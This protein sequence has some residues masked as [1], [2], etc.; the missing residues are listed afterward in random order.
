MNPKKIILQFCF[1]LMTLTIYPQSYLPGPGTMDRYTVFDFSQYWLTATDTQVFYAS[2]DM[3]IRGWQKWDRG[4]THPNDYD[5]SIVTEYHKRN[6]PFIGGMTTTVYFFDEAADSAQFKDMVTHDASGNVIPRNIVG[7]NN[8]RAN[9]ASPAY[10]DYIVS[11]AKIQIDGGVDGLCFDE[12]LSGYDGATYNGN[13][14]FDDY[15]IRDFNVY[16]AAKYPDYT[17]TDW[18]NKFG[19]S[20]SNYINTAQPLDDLNKNFN[21]REYLGIHGWQTN[22]LISSNPLAV[23]WGRVTDNRA[24]TRS[25]TF[26]AKYTMLYWQDIVSRVRQYARDTYGKEILISSNGVFPYVDF[27]ELGMYEFNHDDNGAEASYVP[28]LSGHL[29]GSV[30]LQNL[31]K[32]LYQRN[33]EIAG[34]VPLVLFIDWPTNIMNDYYNLP[35]NEKED[36]WKIYA[37][38]AYANGL[39]M[40]FHLRTAM[41]SDPTATSQ[42]MLD[43]F[44]NYHVFY[45]ENASLFHHN[46]I[47]DRPLK[48]SESG[49]NASLI[50]HPDAS[51]YTI[52]L[53]NHNYIPGKGMI[54]KEGFTVLFH[55]D[56]VPDLVYVKSPDFPGKQIINST[57]SNGIFKITVD[58][59]HYYDI[60][61]LDY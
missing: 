27:N 28:V 22:P 41:P 6:L 34:E 56:S 5:F 58:S 8:Y 44:K 14:G 12:V 48:V 20:E 55:S 57:Y 42:G 10:R 31:F 1:L 7:Y 39:F 11:I 50:Y 47:I 18:I 32:S 13:E 61:V 33:S 54:K 40:A 19:M 16:L 21:Y 3:S 23:E 17:K 45:R 2:P 15:T 4:G 49:I 24:D 59:L 52:H 30:S 43:F 37:A 60:I 53:V 46:Q 9:I 36:Y 51:R 35:R 38:E 29:N 26:L 25:N